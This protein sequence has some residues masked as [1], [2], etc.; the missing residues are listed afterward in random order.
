MSESTVPQTVAEDTTPS[1]NSSTPSQNK[2]TIPK[3]EW[4]DQMTITTC[5]PPDY[6]AEFSERWC[7][8]LGVTLLYR[9]SASR[10]GSNSSGDLSPIR[11][12]G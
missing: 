6:K 1:N 10:S 9:P 2:I 5:D 3:G 8:A 4:H 12:S 7:K 11:A